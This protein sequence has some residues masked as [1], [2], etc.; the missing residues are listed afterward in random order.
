MRILC[1]CLGNIC[2]SPM[3][4]AVLRRLAE[5]EGLELEVDSAGTGSWH[6]GSSPTRE[7]MAAAW[8]RGYD[9]SDQRA[10]QVTPHDF[11]EFDLILAMDR[12]NLSVLE[13]LRPEG[14]HAELRLFHPAGQDVPDPY[15]GGGADYERT[16]DLVEEGARE[17]VARLSDRRP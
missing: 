17:I 13:R 6:V 1:V 2:R 16:L 11:H 3:A 8:A 7:G 10:R 5:A 9:S 15:G 14:A 4:E 12:A